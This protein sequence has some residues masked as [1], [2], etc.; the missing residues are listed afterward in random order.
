V[1]LESPQDVEN[2]TDIFDQLRNTALDP[3]ET[4]TRIARI[5]KEL[6]E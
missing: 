6:E 1:Y 5:S 2:Y 3:S 4:R